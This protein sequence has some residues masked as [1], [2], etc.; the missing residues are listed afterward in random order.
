MF[1][2]L[3]VKTLHFKILL[4]ERKMCFV[5]IPHQDNTSKCL[6]VKHVQYNI[7]YLF[8]YFVSFPLVL[9]EQ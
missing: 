8:P 5:A 4:H 7:P 6:L 9:V 3:P 2:L 1:I